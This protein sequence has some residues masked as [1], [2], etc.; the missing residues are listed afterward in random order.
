MTS[1]KGS[2]QMEVV[3]EYGKNKY[4]KVFDTL[5]MR[6]LRMCNYV[7]VL[8]EMGT[9]AKCTNDE[10]T[11]MLIEEEFIRIAQPYI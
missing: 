6:D 10:D 8:I 3:M 4:S 1:T 11:Y 2:N 7:K 5:S 9:Y